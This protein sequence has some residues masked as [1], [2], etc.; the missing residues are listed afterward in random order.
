MATSYV[1]RRMG[2]AHAGGMFKSLIVGTGNDGAATGTF[3]PD[4]RHVDENMLGIP[5]YSSSSPPD[6]N[7]NFNTF[8]VELAI[9]SAKLLLKNPLDGAWYYANMT[10]V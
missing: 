5:V 1:T 3:R 2:W 10:A 9:G 4:D 8:G 6:V 7:S